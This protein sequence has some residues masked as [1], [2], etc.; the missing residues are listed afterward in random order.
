MF[1]D[2]CVGPPNKVARQLSSASATELI[3]HLKVRKVSIGFG[4]EGVT[5]SDIVYIFLKDLFI[6]LRISPAKKFPIVRDSQTKAVLSPE[7]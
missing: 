2:E 6:S 1:V 4:E 5:A 7:S 3:V